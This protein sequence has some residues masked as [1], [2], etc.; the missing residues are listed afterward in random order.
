[1]CS[2][3]GVFGNKH[4]YDLKKGMSAMQ[5]RGRDAY[6]VFDGELVIEKNFADLSPQCKNVLGHTLHSIVGYNPQPF[7][8]KTKKGQTAFAANCE[9]YNWQELANAQG[10]Q[11]KN[12]SHA[13]FLLLQKL[14]MKEVLNV[15]DG[16]FAFA[17][18]KDDTVVIAR[19]IL[20]EKPLWFTTEDG[21]AF[22][23]EKKALLAMGFVRPEE[24]NP[25]KIIT[26]DMKTKILTEEQRP[27]FDRL[28]E[29]AESNDVI[30]KRLGGLLVNAIAK[31]VPNQPVAILYSG[32]ID[33]LF[34]AKVL[35]ELEVPFT[36]YTA[37]IDETAKDYS[38]ARDS[39][40]KFGFSWKGI[41]FPIETLP[42]LLKKVVP[43]IE[44]STVVKVGVAAT[45]YAACEAAQKDGFRVIFSGLGSEE[46]FAGYE[47]H[48]KTLRATKDFGMV[49]EDCLFGL[50]KLYERD[51]YRDDV[52]TMNNNLELRLP[53][54]DK[55]LVDFSL[56]IPADMKIRGE[57]S[58]LIFRECAEGFGIP[59]EYAFRKKIAAQY[60][61]RFDWAIQKLAKQKKFPIAG[62]YLKT[63]YLYPNVKLGCLF[64]TGKDS[65][66]ALHIMRLRNYEISCLITLKSKNPDSYMFHTPAIELARLQAKA[67]QIPLIEADTAGEKEKE[68]LDL[69]KAIAEAKT[70]FGIQGIVT[71][72]LYSNYQRSRI[73]KICDKLG[74]KIF[75]PLWHIDQEAEL[76]EL[77]DKGF[78]FVMTAVAAE[79]LD[80]SWLGKQITEVEIKKLVELQKKIGINVAGEGGEYESLVLFGP[81]YTKRLQIKKTEIVQNGSSFFLKIHEA[82]LC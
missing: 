14:P 5:N 39:A 55:S 1:M 77:L 26:F 60:G 44:D 79:G 17:F 22:A 31:R 3:I 29:H 13:L 37:A 11:A 27:F 75:A 19:D 45:L 65:H 40:K 54:L 82:T 72:A 16:P 67:M 7:V 2:I 6:G 42:S 51:L 62:A 49:N 80:S 68:L 25:R 20:G 41:L 18:W 78:E 8:S 63:F 81:G 35:Q 28:P 61:S 53:F 15:L 34:I 10:L 43:L 58:K 57:E 30:L 12:D 9:I 52:V 74:L 46:L 4:S 48:R 66:L 64:S 36:C 73:E 32:G 69:E 70:K 47:R 23:S 21:F 33:S 24:L 76:F 71:G 56:K 50:L 38:W 59:K